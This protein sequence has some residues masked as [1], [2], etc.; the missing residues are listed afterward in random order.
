VGL[1]GGFMLR[2]FVFVGQNLACARVHQDFFHTALTHNQ[3]IERVYETA[4]L[5][6]QCTMRHLLRGRWEAS[7]SSVLGGSLG[8]VRETGERCGR[9]VW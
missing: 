3:D 5:D 4:V 2:A 6:F 9:R 1:L 7:E 8:N